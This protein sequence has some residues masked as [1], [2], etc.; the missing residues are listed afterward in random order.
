MILKNYAPAS[1]RIFVNTWLVYLC[2]PNSIFITMVIEVSSSRVVITTQQQHKMVQISMRTLELILNFYVHYLPLVRRKPIMVCQL[3]VS[4]MNF[5]YSLHLLNWVSSAV[6]S[7]IGH[8]PARNSA[9]QTSSLIS[10]GSVWARG[11]HICLAAVSRANIARIHGP[12][13]LTSVS[14]ATET[15]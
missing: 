12:G 5:T 2:A 15:V 4:G 3:I 6:S 9:P 8:H 1:Q 14:T 11:R 10:L 13:A 7:L